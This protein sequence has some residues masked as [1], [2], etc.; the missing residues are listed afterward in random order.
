MLSSV[1]APLEE[2]VR[3]RLALACGVAAL[4]AL[5]P[6][7]D[8]ERV[9]SPVP[10]SPTGLPYT[11]PAAARAA[12]W[13]F[14][15]PEAR[16]GLVGGNPALLAGGSRAEIA[17]D[18]VWRRQDLDRS[19]FDLDRS[20]LRLSSVT[21][22]LHTGAFAFAAAY[23]RPY[24]AS[25]DL[26]IFRDPAIEEDLEVW[27]AAAAAAIAPAV[28]LGTSIAW[29][30]AG[31]PVEDR[32]SYQATLGAEFEVEPVTLAVAFK[33]EPFGEDIDR[34]LAPSWI[35]I[36]ARVAAGPLLA[37]AARMGTGWWNNTLSGRLRAPLDAGLGLAWS[38]LPSLRFLAGAHH[39]RERVDCSNCE[40][41]VA[42]D[43]FLRLDQGTFLD[44]G[45][46]LS[47]PRASVALAVEDNHAFDEPAPLT[48]VTL[49]ANIRY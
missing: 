37:V 20:D 22:K 38:A 1:F 48:R 4:P 5:A 34:L 44:A 26:G 35:Q 45:V 23:Q 25:Y 49:S 15:S 8:F 13:T 29:L 42:V 17:V 9:S 21:G 2:T 32:E 39:V 27:T 24:H 41:S 46:V 19:A 11:I 31:R 36:D 12:G 18:G 28:H 7:Q 30:R 40:P 10:I 43:D 6:A 3:L 47:L 14:A 16:L 33:S